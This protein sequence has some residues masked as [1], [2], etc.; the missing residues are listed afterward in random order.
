MVF[1]VSYSLLPGVVEPRRR[2]PNALALI[3]AD[4]DLLHGSAHGGVGG[5][6]A[7]GM[8]VAEWKK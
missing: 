2:V 3:I 5:A 6:S 1:S 7:A 4:G 8:Q